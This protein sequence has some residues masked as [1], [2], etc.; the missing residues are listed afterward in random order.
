MQTNPL[1]ARREIPKKE[2]LQKA[3]LAL[4]VTVLGA[5]GALILSDGSLDERLGYALAAAAIA[6]LGLTLTAYFWFKRTEVAKTKEDS[7]FIRQRIDDDRQS[8]SWVSRIGF[9]IRRM[10]AGLIVLFGLL[11]VLAGIGVLGVQVVN[12]LRFGEW[13]PVPILDLATPYLPW[14]HNPQSWFGLHRIVRDAFDVMPVSLLLMIVG[15]LIAG[16]GSAV[17]GRV[18]RNAL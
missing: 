3:L 1:M 8:R 5:G 7:Q 9:N 18:D 6:L 12:Y 15:G 10:L 4:G 17:K 14:L 13:Q 16:F 2:R 11:I